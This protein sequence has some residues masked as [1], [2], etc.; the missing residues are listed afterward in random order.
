MTAAAAAMGTRSF[1]SG[2]RAHVG[3]RAMRGR[4]SGGKAGEFPLDFRAGTFGA[5]YL[6][7][8]VFY[9]LLEL[10]AAFRAVIFIYRHFYLHLLNSISL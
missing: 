5:F 9:K 7:L 4:Y 2:G 8:R 1:S 3:R 10:I 6:F